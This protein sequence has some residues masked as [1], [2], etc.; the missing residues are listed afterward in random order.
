MRQPGSA[1]H[2]R[3][4]N[5][6]NISGRL[7]P[8]GIQTEAQIG[9]HL[10]K[11]VQQI[12]TG[13]VALRIEQGAT[14]SCLRENMPGHHDGEKY[15]GHQ[16]G[17]DQHAILRYLSIGNAFHAAEYGI[18]EHNRHADDHT[19]VNVDLEK[20]GEDDTSAAHLTSDIS[21]R[22]KDDTD[23]R[24]GARRTGVV[25]ITDK[26]R[27]GKFAKLS[28]VRRQQHGQQYIAPR[29][30]H[31]VHRGVITRVGNNTGHGNKRCCRHPVG[32]S[33]GAIGHRRHPATRHIKFLGRSG[34]RP[35]RDA[36]IQGK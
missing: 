24:H 5:K 14:K 36:D 7:G 25:T 6:E 33:G 31:Q 1:T 28:Q 13:I 32:G 17:E 4:S 30:A 21:K 2:Q 27:N 23:H 26:I 29:P 18:E 3:S 9:D 19:G 15:G 34:S 11:L 22:D 16:I 35:D 8:F 12:D 20:P 10:I